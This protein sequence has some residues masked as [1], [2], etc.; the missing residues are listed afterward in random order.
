MTANRAT[1]LIFLILA[2]IL[3]AVILR[4]RGPAPLPSNAPSNRFS[5]ARAIVA[6]GSLLGGNERHPIGTR[7][8]D[9]VRDR[10]LAQFRDHGYQTSLQQTFACNAY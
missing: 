4:G 2:L 9:L 7:A 1:A 3:A 6:L 5:A 8:H 10:V